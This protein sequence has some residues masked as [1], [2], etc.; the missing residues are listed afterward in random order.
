MNIDRTQ[1]NKTITYKKQASLKHSN[2]TAFKGG[3][4]SAITKAVNGS[5]KFLVDEPVWGATLIDVGSMVV[6]RTIIDAKNRG[7]NSGFETGF[8]EAESSG[9]DAAIGLY[10]VGAG[11]LIAGAINKKHD[12]KAHTIFASDDAT[13]VFSEKWKHHNGNIDAYARDIVDNIEAFNP[14]SANANVKGYVKIADEH[15]QG[16]IDDLKYVAEGDRT[17]MHDRWKSVKNRLSAKLL[18]AT[19]VE[20][21]F[22]LIHKTATT[23]KATVSNSRTLM[24]NFYHL[25]QSFKSDKVT[26]NVPELVKDYKK[27]AKSRTMLGIATAAF[28]AVIAQPLNVYLSKKRTGSDGFVGVEGRKKDNSAEFKA[29]KAVSAVGMMAISLASMGA[30][31]K[32]PLKIPKLFIEKNQYKGKNPT[33]NHFKSVFGFAI[34]SRLLTARD[35]DEHREVVIKD[36]LGFFNWLMLGSVVNKLILHKF[37]AKDANLLK[38]APKGTHNNFVY[39]NIGNKGRKVYDFLTSSIATHSEVMSAGLKKERPDIKSIVK[40]DGKVMKFSEM[41]KLLPKGSATKKNIK[42]LNWAQLGGYLYSGLMLGIG[43]PKLNIH[44]TNM[45]DK[46]RKAKLEASKQSK[47]I[48]PVLSEMKQVNKKPDKTVFGQFKRDIEYQRA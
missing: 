42:L 37:Q 41:Y 8:R 34:A 9:N 31:S 11:T 15:K 36:V 19:G 39:N 43:I 46:Q 20:D 30:L 28:F 44:I 24:D 6:P 12:I 25:T 17:N 47:P 10:G 4:G 27:F 2:S 22:R 14:N 29:L 3:I 38:F 18:E 40:A 16:I 26:G 32:N 21:E 7:F 1:S 48:A 33:I 23:E 45:K 5:F 35:R 13:D